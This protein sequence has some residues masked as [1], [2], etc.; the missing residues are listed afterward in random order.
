MT[1]PKRFRETENINRRLGLVLRAITGIREPDP[2]TMAT[3]GR[4]LTER[5]EVAARLARAMRISDPAD[6]DKVTVTQFKRA[7]AEGIDAVPDA[8]APLRELFAVVDDVPGWV[9]FDLLNEG[10]RVF[11]RFGR[12]ASDVLTQFALI[13]SYRFAGPNDLLVETGGLTG[14]STRRRLA[15]TQH[16]TIA[17]SGHDA[18]RRDGAGFRLTV[19]V[20]VMH[21]LVNHQ[22][23]PRWD[24]ERWG[25]PINQADLASTL[26]LFNAVQLLGVRMLGVRVSRADSRA[27][28]HLWK[29]IGW[30]MGVDEDW[31]VDL[32]RDQH[33]LNYH[34]LL[35]QSYG[36]PAGPALARATVET[37]R[38]L[39][40]GRFPR[41]RGRYEHARLLSMLSYF[42]GRRG[43][44]D[45]GLGFRLPWAVPPIVIANVARHHV[46]GRTP[47]GRR[48]L[49]RRGDAFT[50]KILRWYFGADAPAVAPVP[51]P[52]KSPAAPRVPARRSPAPDIS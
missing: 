47:A 33:A 25:L 9:D 51:A 18:M 42:L 37:Q 19:H 41:L 30:L 39:D 34:L 22:F 31:L 3:I 24:V 48:W 38:E 4:R 10:G 11:R 40:Y 12:T 32:E 21:A 5:D 45:L 7:L 2:D 50:Q 46:L 15:E 35:S 1:V 44:R 49:E 20:R 23:E 29:Y 43:M 8:P 28:M 36:T 13:G 26:G 52:T 6:P 27:F 16:W 17:A 14:P